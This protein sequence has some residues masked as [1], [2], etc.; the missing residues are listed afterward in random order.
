MC[1]ET[2]TPSFWSLYHWIHQGGGAH[3]VE[4]LQHD[5]ATITSNVGKALALADVFLSM[6]PTQR[7]MEQQEIDIMWSMSRPLGISEVVGFSLS[8][9]ISAIDQ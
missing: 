8:E 3:G 5:D 6:M 1:E 9:E 2:S 7:T 4:V